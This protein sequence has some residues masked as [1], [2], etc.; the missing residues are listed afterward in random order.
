MNDL[1]IKNFF[2]KELN[3]SFKDNKINKKTFKIDAKNV[4]F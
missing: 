2:I 4:T 3:K 1:G